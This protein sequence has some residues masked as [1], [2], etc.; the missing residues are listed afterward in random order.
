MAG[1]CRTDG[2]SSNRNATGQIGVLE[3][4]VAAAGCHQPP[5]VLLQALDHLPDLHLDA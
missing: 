4:A 2:L 1:R 5:A 3:L